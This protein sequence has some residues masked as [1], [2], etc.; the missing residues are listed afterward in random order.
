M[1]FRIIL[2]L[3][4][5]LPHAIESPGP[6]FRIYQYLSYFKEAGI[7]Y[8][9]ST[10]LNSVEY[11]NIY[12]GPVT[13]FLEKSIAAINGISRQIHAISDIKSYDGVIVYREAILFGRPWIESYISNKG[14]PII[15]DF[16]DAIWMYVKSQTGISPILKRLLKP[17]KKFDDIIQLSTHQ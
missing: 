9:I 15:F 10:F 1:V 5:L 4:E 8:K 16:D 2:P 13:S 7:E 3:Y 6:R 14:I 11:M 12:N 17:K